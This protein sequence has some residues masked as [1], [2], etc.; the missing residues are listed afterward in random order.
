MINIP[1]TLMILLK[2]YMKNMSN[3]IILKSKKFITYLKKK[4]KDEYIEIYI[5]LERYL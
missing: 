3:Q 4:M 5:N 1:K 2:N